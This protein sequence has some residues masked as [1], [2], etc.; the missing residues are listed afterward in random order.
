MPVALV[1]ILFRVIVCV[2]FIANLTWVS[3]G[4]RRSHQT[5]T[6]ARMFRCFVQESV[7]ERLKVDRRAFPADRNVDL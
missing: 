3:T 2:E 5:E 6:S 7:C 1:G 4:S